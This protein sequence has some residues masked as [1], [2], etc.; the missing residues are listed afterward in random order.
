ML[1]NGKE[2]RLC[3]V[4]VSRPGSRQP[5]RGLPTRRWS[6]RTGLALLR[7]L[8]AVATDASLVVLAGRATRVPQAAVTSGIQRSITVTR[9]GPFRWA[10]APDLH[11]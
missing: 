11:V 8:G 1:W 5:S 2:A 7:E 6:P 9:R 3:E 4:R 10:N